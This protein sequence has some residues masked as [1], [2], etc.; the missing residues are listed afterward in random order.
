MRR[1]YRRRR[2]AGVLALFVLAFVTFTGA[3]ALVGLFT[4]G[5]DERASASPDEGSVATAGS[6]APIPATVERVETAPYEKPVPIL[7]YHDIDVP[8]ADSP[9]PELFVSAGD[10]G[11]QLDWLDSEGYEPI[12]VEALTL[13]RAGKATLP[14]KPIVLSFDDG[15][16]GQYENAATALATYGW[17]GVLY[18]KVDSLKEGELTDEM[19]ASMIERGWELGAHTI[20]HPDLTQ[21][22]PSQLRREVDGSRRILADRF[23]APVDS[24]AYPA[25][26]YDDT[27][28][29]AVDRAGYSSAVTVEPGLDEADDDPLALPRIRIEGTDGVAGLRAKLTG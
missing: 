4:G 1:V 8:P 3:K 11:R 16:R 5:H 10:F 20:S 21:L 27:V 13:A 22:D 12:T 19:V 23:G 25:G 26:S 15:L 7:M 28:L 14:D 2:I 29:A 6:S 18:L 17:P 9:Y 24:F